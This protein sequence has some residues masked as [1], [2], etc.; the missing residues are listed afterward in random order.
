MKRIDSGIGKPKGLGLFV[1]ETKAQSKW[2]LG[3]TLLL[4]SRKVKGQKSQRRKGEKINPL[5]AGDSG[6]YHKN[7]GGY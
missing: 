5:K 2:I 4:C 7:Q 3:Y 1:K 6:V